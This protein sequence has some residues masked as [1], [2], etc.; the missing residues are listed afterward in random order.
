MRKT[1]QIVLLSLFIFISNAIMAQT[2]GIEF[3]ISGTVIDEQKGALPGVTVKVKGSNKSVVTDLNGKYII[4]ISNE[5]KILQFSFVGM[6]TVEVSI[7]GKSIINVTLQNN[8]KLL[9][10]VVVIGYGSQK[11]N[12][13]NGAISSIS[14]KSIQ[15][16]PSPSVDQLIQGQAAGVTVVQNSG[17]PGSSTT[18]RI[19][20][21]ASFGSS[22]PLYVVDG[23]E[24]S[25]NSSIGQ[26][27][28]PGGG[29]EETSNSSLSFLNPNDI[30]SIDILKDASATAIYGS[31]GANGV[32]IITTKHGKIGNTKVSYDGSVALQQQGKFLKMDNLQQY[33]ALQ[34]SLAPLFY[35]Q[36]R[37]EFANISVLGPGT[38]WQKAIFQ[39]A[40]EQSHNL[41]I[42][43]GSEKADFDISA[44]YLNQDGTILGFDFDRYTI[45]GSVNSKVKD[46]LKFGSNFSASRT[47]QDVGLGNNTGIIYN[48]LLATPDQAIYNADGSFAG[49]A[50]VNG[51][52]LGGPNPVQ[53]ALSITNNLIKN[54][55]NGNFYN[56]I[57]I[58]NGL[59]LRSEIDGDFNWASA[60]TFKPTFQYGATGSQIAYGNSTATLNQSITNTI[61]WSWKEILNYDHKFGKS[62]LTAL[63][64]REVW[65]SN[66]D[67]LQ[68]SGSGFVAGNNLQSIALAN[69]VGSSIP[70]YLSTSVMQSYLTRLIYTYNN[71]YS[72][73]ANIRSDQSSNFAFGHQ[74]GYFPGISASWRLSDE[75]FLS[76]IK[77]VADNVK[78]RIGTGTTGNSSIPQYV[79]GSSL[80]PIPTVFGTGFLIGNTANQNLTWETAIQRDFGVDFTLFNHIDGSFDYFDKTSNHFLFQK[81]LPNFLLGGP[82]DYGDNPAGIAAPFI[83]AGEIENKGFEVSLNSRNINS[84]NFTWNTNLTLS[85]Y[86]NKVVSL[87]GAPAI[88]S[89]LVQSY[90]NISPTQT[91]VGYPEGEFFGYKVQGVIKNQSQLQY[92][93]THPQNVTGTTPQ[94]VSNGQ[95]NTIWLGDLQYQDT[96]NDG[97]VDSKDQVPLGSPQPNF[98][99]SITNTF[100]FKQFDLKIFF[101]GSQGGKVLDVLEYQTAGLSGLY[102]NQLA[103]SSSYWTPSNPNSNIPAPRSGI[104]NP[105]LV[106]SDRFLESAS[107]L[108]LQ[109]VRFGYNLPEKLAK[110]V[111][112][113]SLKI[114]VS[115]QNIFVIS[116]YPGLDPEVGSFNQNPLLSNIDL[117]R[118]PSPRVFTLGINAQL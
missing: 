69:T 97:K 80:K 84:K 36:P 57:V 23:V 40:F 7:N 25:G 93:S 13:I 12:D 115:G 28:R 50:V 77:E 21:I 86:D 70:E 20:G 92:L 49:P 60:K 99:Y 4:N 102:Q 90:I 103:S 62:S 71:K 63:V 110:R 52:I 8:S 78:I 61:Y 85:H 44:G 14:A 43:G 91:I 112:L 51:Q 94:V 16:L 41:S 32:V 10:D 88:F 67:Q 45:H 66:Y 68:L 59:T 24:I 107:F 108:R 34:N 104:G 47:N 26:S 1:L 9:T 87:S 33:A 72:I 46:W 17:A 117:G 65:F 11:R 37:S 83:N 55:I 29:Q 18:I 76:R 74:I 2:K 113:N 75:T 22:E 79:Y 31:R 42:S 38:D 58:F 56:E 54:E 100:T 35:Q 15:D 116:S 48:A 106:M 89:Q 98:T 82:N 114:Y 118:Y 19:R 111:A 96:N 30:Q 6:E 27:I 5:A 101:Y 73:T 53:Q 95:G 3:N 81:P 109:N 105:N 64:G 39:N